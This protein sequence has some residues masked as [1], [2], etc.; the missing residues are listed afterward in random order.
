MK[1]LLFVLLLS[2]ACTSIYAQVK[3]TNL[4]QEVYSNGDSYGYY[5]DAIPGAISY[6]W[7]IQGSGDAIIYPVGDR[8]IDIIFEDPGYYDVICV[9]TMS[10]NSKVTYALYVSV[11]EEE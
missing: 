10:D 6:D 9:V 5:I 2:F 3:E 1:K 8:W 11:T 4:G 7:S